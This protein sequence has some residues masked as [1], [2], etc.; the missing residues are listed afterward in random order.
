MPSLILDEGKKENV[1]IFFAEFLGMAMFVFLGCG[2]VAATGEFLVDDKD[3]TVQVNVA[4]VLPIATS[5]GLSITVL[6]FHLA[7]ISGGHLNPG[8]RNKRKHFFFNI[9]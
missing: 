5:F 2:S 8:K 4:R 9:Y 6:G 3:L 1:K 7:P